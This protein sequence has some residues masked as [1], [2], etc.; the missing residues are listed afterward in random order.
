MYFG[1]EYFVIDRLCQVVEGTQFQTLNDTIGSRYRAERKIT[2]M[3][4]VRRRP[5]EPESHRIRPNR[6]LD[7]EQNEI[8][9]LIA[10]PLQTFSA[11]DGVDDFVVTFQ[12]VADEIQIT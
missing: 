3:F 12:D 8:G 2:G 11:V 1:D 9:V 6:H 5:L 7:V 10:G 4:F